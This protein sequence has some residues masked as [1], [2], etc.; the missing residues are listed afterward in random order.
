MATSPSG[1]NPFTTGVGLGCGAA[2]GWSCLAPLL[3]CLGMI[4]LFVAMIGSCAQLA[5]Q[6]GSPTVTPAGN[7]TTTTPPDP[8]SVPN[9]VIVPAR[10]YSVTYRVT[11][12]AAYV[13]NLKFYDQ[14]GRLRLIRKARVPWTMTFP[15]PARSRLYLSA[16]SLSPNRL[17]WVEI[18]LNGKLVQSLASKRGSDFVGI[19]GVIG[20]RAQGRR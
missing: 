4:L 18:S 15:A 6:P 16:N 13:H 14:Y 8:G 19:A 11:A 12:Q 1:G 9:A 3:G 17:V 10:T 7:V 20:E 5:R 2:L